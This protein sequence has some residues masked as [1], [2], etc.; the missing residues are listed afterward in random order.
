M[1]QLGDE[2]RRYAIKSGTTLLVDRGQH[3]QRVELLDHYLRTAVRQDIHRGQYH[4]EAVEQRNAAAELV[5][6]RELHVFSRQE[7][8]IGNIV[9]GEH[10]ALGEARRTG[11]VLHVDHIV[12]ADLLFGRLQVVV[13][14]IFA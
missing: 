14:D 9:V 4:A 11:G 12:A 13:A 1:V 2:H 10:N 3:H 7:T 8:I 5:V 6:C